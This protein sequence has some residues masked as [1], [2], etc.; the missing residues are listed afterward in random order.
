M[1]PSRLAA[2]DTPPDD[3][4]RAWLR[5]CLRTRQQVEDFVS[6]DQNAERRG[7]TKGWVYDAELG[8]ALTDA[9]RADGVDGSKTFYHYEPDGARRL[10][11]FAGQPCRIHA[12]GDS[13][14]HCDQVSDGETWQEYLAA[15]LQEPVRNYGVGGYSVYQ[16]YRRMLKVE[17][18]GP[19][20]AGAVILTIFDDDHFRNLDSWRR[21]RSGRQTRCGFTLPHL[22]VNVETGECRERE[23]LLREPEEVYKLCEAEWVWE[24]FREDPILALVLAMRAEESDDR[25][26]SF[27]AVATSFGLLSGRMGEGSAAEAARRLHL[28]AALLATRSVVER[29]E[30]FVQQTGKRLMVILAFGRRNMAA[31]L[32]EEP[33]FDQPLLDFLATRTYPVID[34]RNAFREEF[35]H[36]LLDAETFLGRHYNGHLTPSGN[37]FTAWAIKDRVVEW[38][39]PRPAPYG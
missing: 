25:R 24:T 15:H 32:R 12:Y 14:T 20:R 19:H 37:C 9:V 1:P 3:P 27:E 10:V 16:A 31:A 33:R 18:E 28:Q 5:S 30:A 23:N 26:E 2:A 6:T 36:S 17:R 22:R 21:L 4:A 35:R 8:W 7:R 39:E 29:V 34:M 38:L 11:N 13:F